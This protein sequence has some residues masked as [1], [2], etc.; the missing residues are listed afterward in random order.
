MTDTTQPLGRDGDTRKA[1]R[2]ALDPIR[3]RT[4]AEA[5]AASPTG[6]AVTIWRTGSGD[7]AP[8]EIN[9]PFEQMDACRALLTVYVDGRPRWEWPWHSISSLT[10]HYAVDLEVPS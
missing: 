9:V 5:I 7:Y 2:R 6:H 4:L 10:H 8:P 1:R 3:N